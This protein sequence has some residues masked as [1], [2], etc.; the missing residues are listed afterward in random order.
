LFKI[1]QDDKS[2]NGV[3]LI[4]N[5]RIKSLVSDIKEVVDHY[6]NNGSGDDLRNDRERRFDKH[7]LHIKHPEPLLNYQRIIGWVK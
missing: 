6:E 5:F 2:Y 4:S 1:R 3:N 7:L